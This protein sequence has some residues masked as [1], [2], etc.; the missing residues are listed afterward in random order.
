MAV[1]T[2]FEELSLRTKRELLNV[3]FFFMGQEFCHN[4]KLSE[5]FVFCFPRFQLHVNHVPVATYLSVE[6]SCMRN[7][8]RDH[9]P[10]QVMPTEG[11]EGNNSFFPLFPGGKRQ[12]FISL[13]K[14]TVVSSLAL[15]FVHG[16]L[17]IC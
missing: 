14:L 4:L 8:L 16:R 15:E 17:Q 9:H 2:E 5:N 1:Q 6:N 13:C 7:V 10:S 11:G 12:C 3:V